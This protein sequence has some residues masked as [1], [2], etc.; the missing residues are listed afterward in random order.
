MK[1]TV[2]IQEVG[3]SQDEALLGSLEFDTADG[4]TFLVAPWIDRDTPSMLITEGMHV[5]G[6]RYFTNEN[7]ITVYVGKGTLIL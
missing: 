5:I 4:A 2:H 1:I 6:F 7:S 3:V